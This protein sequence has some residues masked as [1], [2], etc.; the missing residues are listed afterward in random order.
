MAG[1]HQIW[2]LDI[3][4]DKL[5]RHSGNGR[6]GCLND[7]HSNSEWA[8]PSGITEGTIDGKRYF[9]VADSESSSIRAVNLSDSNLGLV[10]ASPNSNDL[11]AF[12]DKD[13]AGFG[14]RL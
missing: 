4:N 2:M 9:F 10:G 5:Y 7:R 3:G 13:G 14:A 1:T 12:G 6:E 11:F 8:Q